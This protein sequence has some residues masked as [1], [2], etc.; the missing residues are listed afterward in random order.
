[1]NAIDRVSR[2][3]WMERGMGEEEWREKGSEEGGCMLKSDGT[4][5]KVELW[6]SRA[7]F[8]GKKTTG[9]WKAELEDCFSGIST[10]NSSSNLLDL[11]FSFSFL[12]LF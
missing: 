12:F 7:M 9:M 2:V 11:F 10:F 4:L 3:G 6:Y 1:M 8:Y 5:E